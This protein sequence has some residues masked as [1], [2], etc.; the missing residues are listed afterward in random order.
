MQDD[1]IIFAEENDVKI[2]SVQDVWKVL[3]VDDEVEV[4]A[5]TRLVLENFVFEEKKIE[6]ISVYSAEEAKKILEKQDD[7]ALVLLDVVMER[8]DAGLRLVRYIREELG[9]TLVRI[10]LRTGQPGAA[11]ESR[12]IV[13]YDINDY[14][15]KTEL[16]AQ[17]LLTTVI[18][19][20]RSYR[21]LLII[22][23]NK[24]GLEKIIQASPEIFRMQSMQNFA[25]GVLMQLTAMLKL[26]DNSLYLKV[27]SFA[28]TGSK[29]GVIDILAATGSFAAKPEVDINI[30]DEIKNKLDIVLNA[31]KSMFFAGYF[32]LYWRS[33]ADNFYLIYMEGTPR[34]SDLDKRLLD[35]FCLN[36]SA[37]FEN[38]KLHLEM[39]DVQR[40][41]FFRLAEVA[42]SRS[43]ETGNHVRRVAEYVSLLGKAYGLSEKEV[44]MIHLAAP[45]HDIGKLGIPDEILNKPGKLTDAEFEIIK[46]HT[47]IGYDMLDGSELEMLKIAAIIAEQHH[48]RYDGT[49]YGRGL[50]GKN[51]HIYARITAVADVFDALGSERVYKKAWPLEKII[52]YFE[53]GRGSQFDPEIVDLLLGNLEQVLRIRDTFGT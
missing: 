6:L 14:K 44:D 50:A 39:Y 52:H 15:E 5:V 41:V 19:A 42:E 30:S 10:I 29:T 23:M 4:H 40:E 27:S 2:Y 3:I 31:Q 1:T 34:I 18:T 35:I 45:M 37:A 22:E 53:Q 24:N 32:V 21:D 49:G 25:A 20:I 28:A 47:R 17:K 11:P 8:S 46:Q 33:L 26:S 16:T 51:I 43:K 36:I 12:V 13:E 38:L 7:I 9:N 48:E